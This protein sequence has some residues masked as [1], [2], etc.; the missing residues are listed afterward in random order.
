MKKILI[1]TI[2]VVALMGISL[3]V[4]AG[5]K[6]KEKTTVWA[7]YDFADL[8]KGKIPGPVRG[9]Y[10]G[11]KRVYIADLV[12]NQQVFSKYS[13]TSYGGMNK[14]TAT[15]R[16]Q[17]NLGGVDF[18]AYQQVVAELYAQIE[19]YYRDQGF[20][21]VTEEEVKKTTLYQEVESGKRI[22]MAN[23]SEVDP[24]R[25]GDGG[26]NKFVSVRPADIL[27]VYNDAKK[28]VLTKESA[29]WKVYFNLANELNAL[30]V[31]Y[32]FT[33][34]FVVMGGSGGYFASSAK[35]GATPEMSIYGANL[36]TLA[37]S[38]KK[39]QPTMATYYQSETLTGN[40]NGWISPEG[41]V[42]LDESE[43][44]LYWSGSSSKSVE[45]VMMVS[46]TPFLEEISVIANGLNKALTEQFISDLE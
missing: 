34:N 1:L 2:L 23:A 15:A 26:L 13:K 38:K 43:N 14:G 22:V 5:G 19:K 41:F 16:M 10:K 46:Q 39:T 31:S 28:D 36:F 9:K 29:P 33:S 35:V 8:I 7:A 6:K 25:Y 37:P 12:I 30:V 27:V 24:V 18:N 45:N 3:T 17:V 4:A 20:E 40:N 11:V 32:T 44:S 42:E 21:I